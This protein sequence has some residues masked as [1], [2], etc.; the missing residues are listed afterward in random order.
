MTPRTL[1]H[2]SL[3]TIREV[4]KFLHGPRDRLGRIQTS[5]TLMNA[6]ASIHQ[7]L[8]HGGTDGCDKAAMLLQIAIGETPSSINDK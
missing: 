1:S 2:D 8:P 6:P 5:R 7:Q 3:E 4:I